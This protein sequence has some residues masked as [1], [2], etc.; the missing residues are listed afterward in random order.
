MN[1]A[2]PDDFEPDDLDRYA[3]ET[4]DADEAQHAAPTDRRGVVARI[5]S[6]THT[7]RGH[8]HGDRYTRKRN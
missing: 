8:S 2:D 5:V 4:D 6:A 3:F 7:A 1:H